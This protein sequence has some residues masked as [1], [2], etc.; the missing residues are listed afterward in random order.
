[1]DTKNLRARLR[2]LRGIQLRNAA[3]GTRN[4]RIDAQI[5]EAETELAEAIA[6]QDREEAEAFGLGLSLMDWAILFGFVALIVGI[7][8]H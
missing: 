7:Y 1:M 4:P 8:F 6:R 3:H 2:L 5:A